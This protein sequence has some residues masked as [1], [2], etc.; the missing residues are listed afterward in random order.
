MENRKTQKPIYAI[1]ESAVLVGIALALSFIKIP[2]AALGGSVDFVMVP[3]FIICY[4]RGAFYGT[5]SGLC[6]GLLKCIISGGIGWGLLSVLLD[7]VLAYGA[8]GVAGFFK[9]KS[10]LI[11]VSVIVGCF[12]RFL[13]HFVSGITIYKILVP[14]AV[15]GLPFV[16]SNPFVYSAVYNSVYMLPNTVIAVIMM[17]VLRVALKKLK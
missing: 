5:I 6:F 10:K 15:E 1:C 17:A 13:V 8:V 3:L 2:I 11:E 7:Y 12:A 16:F 4:R 14:T 9:N